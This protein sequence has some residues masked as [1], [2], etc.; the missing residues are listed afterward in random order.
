M[1]EPQAT[2]VNGA[3]LR[4]RLL[5][6]YRRNRRDLPWRGRDAWGVWVSEVMLQQTRAAFVERYYEPFLRRFP[7]PR[8]LAEAPMDEAMVHWE[9]LGYYRRLD[10]LKESASRVAREGIPTRYDEL[11]RLPGLGEYTAAA[12]ASIAF[13]ERVAA[14]DGN[15][16][17]V[18]ARVACLEVGGAALAGHARDLSHA[19]MGKSAEPGEWN[20]A[21]MELGATVCHPRSPKCTECPIESLCIA[22]SLGRQ[23]DLPPRR[24]KRMVEKMH[25]VVCMVAEGRVGVRRIAEGRWWRGMYEFP[26]IEVPLGKDPLHALRSEG[27]TNLRAF[28]EV[29]HVVTDHR[30]TLKAFITDSLRTDKNLVLATFE[31]LRRLPMPAAQRRVARTLLGACSG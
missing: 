18:V 26:R 13:G 15:V 5:A 28:C 3:S 23:A 14:V 17:R 12:V 7:T 11:R 24:Q 4:R 20:Q 10:R 6:W 21:M 9:G 27:W 2:V 25:A 8:A 16:A 31:E 19:W 22:R 30:I 1:S 29:R